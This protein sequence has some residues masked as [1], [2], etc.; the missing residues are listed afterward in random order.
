[1]SAPR[2]SIRSSASASSPNSSRRSS[3]CAAMPPGAVRRSGHRGRAGPRPVTGVRR[4]TRGTR[5]RPASCGT[6][7]R[8]ALRADSWASCCAARSRA[9]ASRLGAGPLLAGSTLAAS[10][11]PSAWASA[12][13]ESASA[14]ACATVAAASASA[15]AS[16]S[17]ASRSAR[18]IRVVISGASGSLG[19][20]APS[21]GAGAALLGAG[22]RAGYGVGRHC[23]ITTVSRPAGT[24][25]R[26]VEHVGQD[27]HDHVLGE[28]RR[29]GADL[30]GGVGGHHEEP[31]RLRPCTRW[32]SPMAAMA[33]MSGV[34][35]EDDRHDQAVDRDPLGQSTMTI[36]RPKSWAARSS[37]PALPTRCSPPQSPRRCTTRR[38]RSIRR[39]APP[40]RAR[41]RRRGGVLGGAQR[42]HWVSV[43]HQH[44]DDG[45]QC[46]QHH[47]EHR[48]SPAAPL[49]IRCAWPRGRPSRR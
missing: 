31:S 26:A 10:A 28:R 3:A 25:P 48:G 22:A 38:R 46:R 13:I 1:M 12:R 49:R 40:S 16:T 5:G 23:G 44:Q 6:A 4:P 7:S 8:A 37:W 41:I 17:A 19:A 24:S 27:H 14:R 20:G 36:A 30:L 34:S 11:A 35:H 43:G 47:A 9:R 33:P 2:S 15:W 39:A 32:A 18:S 45:S 21:P 29:T 42:H